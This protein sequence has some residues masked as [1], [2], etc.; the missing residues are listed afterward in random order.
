[1][2]HTVDS[3]SLV[4]CLIS[5]LRKDWLSPLGLGCGHS[6]IGSEP[7]NRYSTCTR[8]PSRRRLLYDAV[9]VLGEIFENPFLCLGTPWGR[10]GRCDVRLFLIFETPGQ[11]LHESALFGVKAAPRACEG[12]NGIPASRAFKQTSHTSHMTQHTSKH[13]VAS[14]RRLLQPQTCGAWLYSHLN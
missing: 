5:S 8:T 11:R 1:M 6:Q 14:L 9:T 3:R 2:S 12:M 10:A 7:G 4:S 13:R